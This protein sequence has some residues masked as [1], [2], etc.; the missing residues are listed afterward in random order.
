MQLFLLKSCPKYVL[1]VI[2]IVLLLSSC[3]VSTASG[4]NPVVIS[5][6]S[7]SLKP[8]V[9]SSTTTAAMACKH[10]YD[11]GDWSVGRL[12]S[13]M[14][15]MSADVTAL[16]DAKMMVAQGVGGLVIMGNATSRS[17]GA[18]IASLVSNSKDGLKPLIMTDEEGG[19]IQR[20]ASIV[21]SM[22][23]PRNA[24]KTMSVSQVESQA[25]Q[26]GRG[27]AKIGINIDLAPVVDLDSGPGPS[28]SNPDGSR[29]YSINP[30]IT[31]QYA[32][33]FLLGL[34]SA[35]V[36]PVLKHFPGLGGSSGNTDVM[37]AHTLPYSELISGALQ[38][39]EKLG[40]MVKI[41]MISNASVPGLSQGIPSSLSPNVVGVLQNVVKFKGVIISDS[42][43]TV[44]ISSYQPNLGVAVVDSA[45]AGVDLIMLAS[46]SPN[47][48][49]EFNEAKVALS[50]AISEGVISRSIAEERVGKIFSLKGIS[51]QCIYY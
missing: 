42:L 48:N 35:G 19:G 8:L 5:S 46:A 26:V 6:T 16:S 11:L 27:L 10:I 51:N 25:A 37:A 20:F 36:Q 44:S 9:S 1:S 31:S 30:T 4:E 7:T 12:A 18:Q 43:E 28:N 33:A 21:G 50:N 17:I 34:E 2:C 39:Y 15:V 41:I 14:L 24:V 22:P 38:P 32:K 29:S 3:G 23:W 45:R 49:L 13:Q 40:S 47:Q